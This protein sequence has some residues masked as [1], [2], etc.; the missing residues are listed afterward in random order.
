MQDSTVE[1]ERLRARV[2]ELEG[3]LARAGGPGG[4]PMDAIGK[5]MGVFKAILQRAPYGVVIKDADMRFRLVNPRYCELLGLRREDLLGKN[6]A[7]LFPPELARGFDEEDRRVME[8]MEP[9]SR[10]SSVFFGGRH[11]WLRVHKSP[12]VDANGLVYGVLAAVMDVTE[13]Q[14]YKLAL[15]E[16]Q[17]RYHQLFET[18]CAIKMIVDPADG[19]ILDVNQAA[20]DFYGY[21]RYALLAMNAGDLCADGKREAMERL[22][23]LAEGCP[24]PLEARHLLAS[25]QIRDVELYHGLVDHGAHQ[26]VYVIIHDIT[27][28]KRAEQDLRHSEERLELALKGAGMAM[29]DHNPQSGEIFIDERIQ[30]LLG[31]DYADVGHDAKFFWSLVLP[32]D[33]PLMRGAVEQ[34][35]AGQSEAISCELRLRAAGGDY[36]W[37]QVTGRVVARDEAGKPSRMAGTL[38][39]ISR[40]KSAEQERERLIAELQTALAQVRTLSG[41]LPICSHCKKIRDDQGYWNQLEAYVARHSNAEFTHS[42][43]P[44]CAAKLCPE[45]YARKRGDQ[46]EK[47]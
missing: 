36:R 10:T 23:R 33:A 37:V 26:Y 4:G 28:R 25:G 41:L 30:D 6:A 31:H 34:N 21:P 46:A 40:R 35:L 24:L 38:L 15:E 43:C 19:S 17:R 20:C 11:R 7:E 42:I 44:E 39:D 3:Q 13:S 47:P 8:T 14:V 32:E 2:R 5:W 22:R 12:I 29:W 27:A 45:I 18:N 9:L 1:M 16:S